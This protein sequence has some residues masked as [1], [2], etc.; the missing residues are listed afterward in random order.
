QSGACDGAGKCGE[1]KDC[2]VFTCG[3]YGCASFCTRNTDCC[4]GSRFCAGGTAATTPAAPLACG[5]TVTGSTATG[6]QNFAFTS[7]C[8]LQGA[9]D[10]PASSAWSGSEY[11]GK[12]VA[13]A[14]GMFSVRMKRT[15]TTGPDLDLFVFEAEPCTAVG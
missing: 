15:S 6:F 8:T 13:P 14:S 2:G 11:V 3:L 1:F 4:G 7:L 9:S 12:I 10:R 5:A